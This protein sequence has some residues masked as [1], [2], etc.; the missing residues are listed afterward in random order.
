MAKF[1]VIIN[2]GLAGCEHE[3]EFE[4]G[5]DWLNMHTEERQEEII[6]EEAHEIMLGILDYSWEKIDD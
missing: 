5:D 6:E 3:E 2:I 4:I 1:K